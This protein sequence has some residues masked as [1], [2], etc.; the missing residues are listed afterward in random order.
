MENFNKFKNKIVLLVNQRDKRNVI[1]ESSVVKLLSKKGIK[2]QVK[3][4]VKKR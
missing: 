1:R 3:T 4:D 2:Y